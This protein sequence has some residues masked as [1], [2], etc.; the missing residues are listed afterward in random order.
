MLL[1][2]II[3]MYIIIVHKKYGFIK[4]QVSIQKID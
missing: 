2:K 4:K 1:L 3:N